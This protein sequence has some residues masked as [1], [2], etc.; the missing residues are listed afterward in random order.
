MLMDLSALKAIYPG[1]IHEFLLD[2]LVLVDV[3]VVFSRPIGMNF[4]ASVWYSCD[5]VSELV[6]RDGRTKCYWEVS[7]HA[8]GY[9]QV[10]FYVDRIVPLSEL[11]LSTSLYVT[12]KQTGLVIILISRGF[13][14]RVTHF[15]IPEPIHM[16]N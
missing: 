4:V 12:W 3:Q 2:S 6:P 8:V 5:L 10:N 1:F 14:L 13:H 11:W 16:L 7:T 9:F 15:S